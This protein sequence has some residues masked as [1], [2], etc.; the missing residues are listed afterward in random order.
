MDVCWWE[1]VMTLRK[2]FVGFISMNHLGGDDFL[3]QNLVLMVLIVS[4][5]LHLLYQPFNTD[6]LGMYETACLLLSTMLF[7]SGILSMGMCV[8]NC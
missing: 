1:G 7:M 4:L 5:V 3:K 6:L 2:V 8:C